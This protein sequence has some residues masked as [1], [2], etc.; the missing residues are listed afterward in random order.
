LRLFIIFFDKIIRTVFVPISTDMI[1]GEAYICLFYYATNN[2]YIYIN[3]KVA[4]ANAR[5]QREGPSTSCVRRRRTSFF[6]ENRTTTR[7]ESQSNWNYVRYASS[8][9][10]MQKRLRARGGSA[11][12]KYNLLAWRRK[13]LNRRSAYNTCLAPNIAGSAPNIAT[14]STISY[15]NGICASTI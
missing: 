10:L 3:K 7:L 9:T 5:T 15:T 4:N 14:A 12:Q 6:R 2:I 8:E 1:W 11:H 13:Q